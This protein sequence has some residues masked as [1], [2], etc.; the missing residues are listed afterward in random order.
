MR[1][2]DQVLRQEENN[3]IQPFLWVHGEAEEILRSEIRK[4]N[5]CHI[6]SLCVEARPHDDFN[7]DGWFRDLGI[8][9][10]EC[11]ALGM[12]MWVLDDSHFPTGYADGAVKKYHPEYRKQFLYCK[13]MDFAGPIEHSGAILKYLLR[14]PQDQVVSLRLYRK[15]AFETIN[16][17]DS[18]DLTDSIEWHEDYDTGKPVTDFMGHP[19]GDMKHGKCPSVRFDLLE[20]EWSLILVASSYKGGEKQTA[21][22]L[23]PLRKEATDVLLSTVYEPIYEHLGNEFGSAFRGFFS[24]EPRFG[25]IHGSEDASIGRNSQMDLPWCDNLLDQLTKELQNTDLKEKDAVQLLPLLFINGVEDRDQNMI[26]YAYMNLVSRLYSE[27]FDGE[28]ASWC[29]AHHCEHIGH[30]IEDNNATAR[31]GYGAGHYFRAVKHQDMAGIDVVIQQLLPGQNHGLF[32]GMH[33]PGWDGEFF[34]YVLGKLGSSE[35]HLNPQHHNR[36]M[37]ELFGAYGWA[38]GNKLCKW[39]ADYMLVRGVNEFVPHAFDPAPFPDADCPPHFYAHGNNPQYREFGILM[40]YLNRMSEMLSGTEVSTVALLY[41]GE[42]EWSGEYMLSQ[43]P[44]AL[45]A[46]HQIDYQIVPAD[47][48]QNALLKNGALEINS[49][50]FKTID[51]KSTRLNSSH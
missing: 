25:N 35:A 13:V 19:V 26:R 39:Q 20:G 6:K 3:H 1:I 32:K 7:G 30:T 15:T 37:C 28:I 38:E 8:I 23:N 18:L 24:D 51:R 50:Q 41:H 40:K 14:T 46:D 34:T 12:T 45:L 49:N 29:H 33:K 27:N 21:D 4:I 2:V 31:L 5:E 48:F 22:Y 17:N 44:A 11:K 36:C 9:L 43:K 16:V 42:A 47:Y 10:D